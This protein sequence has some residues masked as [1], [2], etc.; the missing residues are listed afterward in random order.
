LL[1]IFFFFVFAP[2]YSIDSKQEKASFCCLSYAYTLAYQVC[3]RCLLLHTWKMD[4]GGV[5]I[6][7]LFFR[8][9]YSDLLTNG[10]HY[11]LPP[12]PP[13]LFPKTKE[14]RV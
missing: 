9:N 8:G 5:G 7:F 1:F 2:F 3:Q 12:P 6:F 4:F 14:R 11:I 13:P 10:I